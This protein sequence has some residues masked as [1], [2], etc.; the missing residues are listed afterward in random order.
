LVSASVEEPLDASGGAF[1]PGGHP[2][3]R[4]PDALEQGVVEPPMELGEEFGPIVEVHVEGALRVACRVG[5]RSDGE[6]LDASIAGDGCCS[7]EKFESSRMISASARTRTSPLH[8]QGSFTP[9][10]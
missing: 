4:V 8:R 2:C 7:I 10:H 9:V 5:D 6:G 3:G 1:G